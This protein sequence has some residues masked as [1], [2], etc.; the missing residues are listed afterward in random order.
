MNVK[1]AYSLPQIQETLQCLWWAIWFMS[2]D[3]KSGYWQVRMKEECKAYM[4]F[5]VGPLGFYECKSFGL[6]NAPATFQHLMETCFSNLQLTWYIIY[7]DDINSL[8]CNP[9]GALGDATSGFTKLRGVG[10][11]AKPEKCNFFKREIVYLGHVVSQGRVWM[12]EHKIKAVR[13]LPVPPYHNGGQVLPGVCQLLPLVPE[14]ICLGHPSIVWAGFR[15]KCEWEQPG[16]MDW[17]VPKGL[18]QNQGPLLHC[19]HLGFCRFQA[20]FCSPHRCQW[21]WPGCSPLS[22]PWR[23]RTSDRV[24]KWLLE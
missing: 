11:K 9:K 20:A 2:L 18:W 5:T 8:H 16:A 13:K 21:E 15:R 1:D 3:L 14:G 17:Q 6:R 23:K 24:W 4:A 22:D 19:P 10:L 12:D 7:L